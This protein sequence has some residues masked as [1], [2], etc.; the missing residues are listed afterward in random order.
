MKYFFLDSFWPKGLRA[1]SKLAS[2]GKNA[3]YQR[4]DTEDERKD[5]LSFL[6]K[7]KD[8]ET[9]QPLTEQEIIAESISFIVGGSDTTSTT[10]TNV[11]EI[12]SRLPNIQK[13]LQLE[14][15]TAFPGRMSAN[16]VADSQTVTQLP[17]LNA[18]VRETMR[19]KPTSSTGLERVV[20]TGGRMIA[21]KFITEGVSNAKMPV[22]NTYSPRRRPS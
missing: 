21:G 20:P 12:V 17:I 18:V 14:L 3:Y 15:D 11:V 19:L 16:W 2:I 8:P 13:H 4:K 7:A 6:F 1:T 5:L 22:C 10:M 9:K